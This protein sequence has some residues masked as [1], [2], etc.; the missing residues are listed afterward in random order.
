MS[1]KSVLLFLLLLLILLPALNRSR[2][3]DFDQNPILTLTVENDLFHGTDRWYTHGI[4]AGFLGADNRVPGWTRS[5][6]QNVPTLGYSAGAE[7]LGYQFGQSIYTP[8]DTH[9]SGMVLNDRPYAG[10]LFGGMIYQRRGEGLGD[11]LTLEQF[12]LQAGV[13]GPESGARTVQSWFHSTT[14]RGWRHQLRTEPGVNLKYGRAWIIPFPDAVESKFDI[15]PTAGVSAGNVDTSFRAGAQFRLGWNLPKDFG[16]QAI[17]SVIAT[18]GGLSASQASRRGFYI[19]S[20]VEGR[21]QLYTAFLDGNLF[22]SSHSVDKEY[23]VGEWRNGL[24]LI[25]HRFEL[26]YLHAFRTAEFEGQGR[27]HGYGAMT[28]KF[29]F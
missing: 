5:L 26:A 13:I 15:I 23:F 29:K 17:D 2:A 28:L 12:Q 18:E 25:L 27:K 19:F 14:P 8:A 4:R 10:W 9:S 16:V 1:D 7:R 6:F 20:G 11:L 24:V 22:R 3:A 21:A